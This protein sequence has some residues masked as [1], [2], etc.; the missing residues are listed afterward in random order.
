M[1]GGAGDILTTGVSGL[2]TVLNGGYS[3][4]RSVVIR[5]ASGAGKT[6][7]SLL[8][9]LSGSDAAPSVFATFDE[10]PER[11]REYAEQW[12]P[13]V[14]LEILD[15]RPD[16]EMVTAGGGIE[17]GGMLTR[18]AHAIDRT[19]AHRLVLDAFDV[20]FLAFQDKGQMR[21]DLNRV[22]LW[23]GDRGV[24][25]MAT[26]GEEADYRESTGLMEYVA[27]CAIRLSQKLDKGL[28]VRMLRVLK[29]RGRAHGTN[30]YPFLIDE[31]GVAMLPVTDTGM[32]LGQR[33]HR[34]STGIDGLD[35]MLAGG[36]W[37]GTTVMVSGQSGL[38]KSLLSLT[39]AESICA[40]GGRV[41]YCSFEEPAEQLVGDARSIGMDLRTHWDA[42][43][44]VIESRRAVEHGLEEHVIALTRMVEEIK[45]E[46]VVLDPINALADMGDEMALKSV[47]L[48]LCHYLK[49]SGITTLM[50]EL[51]PDHRPNASR[52][53]VSSLVDSWIRLRMAE[54]D[55][56]FHRAIYIHKS[57]GSSI[58]DRV[59]PYR[60]TDAGIIV[61]SGGD[62]LS[63]ETP[64]V[65]GAG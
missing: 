59:H 51:L 63:V 40:S 7:F 43:R 45:P 34:L 50:T 16:P 44:L 11:L 2:D 10:A 49:M 12:A 17:L 14:E 3:K 18:I 38:G 52:L 61:G 20:L 25:V 19:G 48:R 1:N 32:R 21:L 30:E 47:V 54:R 22:L 46:L 29:C 64:A 5:G 35:A 55:G 58:S 23:C 31:K 57:R 42:G 6:V 15:L 9:A 39:M 13:G 24:T 65:S 33:D 41:L 28:M 56:R 8:Y 4:G 27:D 37:A 62:G 26:T 36:V 60:I 53:N